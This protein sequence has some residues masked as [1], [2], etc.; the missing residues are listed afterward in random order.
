MA[1]EPVTD[2][3]V[4]TGQVLWGVTFAAATICLKLG[5]RRTAFTRTGVPVEVGEF[6]LNIQCPCVIVSGATDTTEIGA[7]VASCGP[8]TI[9]CVEG[10]DTGQLRLE[11]DESTSLLVR[12]DQCSPDEQWR[13][14]RSGEDGA[15][16]VFGG[17]RL[18]QQ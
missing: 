18:F 9:K 7:F 2:V 5:E 10:A 16:L 1:T 6:A 4:L 13:L 3:N 12:A 17:G 11:F 15:H 8:L 14:F